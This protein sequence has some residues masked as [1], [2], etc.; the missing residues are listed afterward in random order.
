M[1]CFHPIWK[2]AELNLCSFWRVQSVNTEGSITQPCRPVSLLQWKSSW[3]R[4]KCLSHAVP[5]K[6]TNRVDQFPHGIRLRIV[7]ESIIIHCSWINHSTCCEFILFLSIITRPK[8]N[9][10]GTL[11][12]SRWDYQATAQHEGEAADVDPLRSSTFAG[13]RCDSTE[14][15]PNP[16]ASKFPSRADKR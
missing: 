15:S 1:F 5:C 14:Q 9:G 11:V 7:F 12:P 6:Q 13:T 3:R 10:C 2:D 16:T 8:E 4:T